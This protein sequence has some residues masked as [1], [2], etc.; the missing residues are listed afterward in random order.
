MVS[1]L[2]QLR[3]NISRMLRQAVNL[4][5]AVPGMERGVAPG[6]LPSNSF[7]DYF[8]REGPRPDPKLLFLEGWS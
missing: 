3:Q 7:T 6:L 5:D 8:Q 4:R 2:H 1:R